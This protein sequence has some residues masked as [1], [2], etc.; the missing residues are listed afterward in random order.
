MPQSNCG[1]EWQTV[2]GGQET[3][4]SSGRW[5]QYVPRTDIV[6]NCAMSQKPGGENQEKHQTAQLAAGFQ[7]TTS[8]SLTQLPVSECLSLLGHATVQQKSDNML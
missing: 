5:G 1:N 3:A 8:Q 4:G 2:V 7:S 6:L